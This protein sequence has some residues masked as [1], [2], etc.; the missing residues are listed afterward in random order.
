[1]A[2]ID[3]VAKLNHWRNKSQGAPQTIVYAEDFN[4]YEKLGADVSALLDDGRLSE[5]ALDGSYAPKAITEQFNNFAVDVYGSIDTLGSNAVFNVETFGAV[6][7]NST[8]CT[9]AIQAAI[10]AAAAAGGGVVRFPNRGI[11]RI[12]GPQRTGTGAQSYA[13]SGQL[14][15]PA[16]TMTADSR[17]VLTFE[18]PLMAPQVAWQVGSEPAHTSGAILLSN[19]TT[20]YVF[21]GIAGSAS[22]SP[23]TN[24]FGVFNNMT[25][26]TPANP[27]CGGLNALTLAGISMSGCSIDVNSPGNSIPVPTGTSYGL[28]LPANGNAAFVHATDCQIAGYPV[29]LSHAEHAQLHNVAVQMCA[30]GVRPQN[31]YTHGASY[32]RLLLQEC[33]IGIQ[34]RNVPGDGGTLRGFVDFEDHPGTVWQSTCFIDDPDNR[35]YGS[36]EIYSTTPLFKS[37]PVRGCHKLNLS[38]SL[39]GAVGW[40]QS[41]P[42]DTFKRTIDLPNML[43]LCDKSFHPWIPFTPWT[44]INTTADADGY[45]RMRSETDGGIGVAVVNWLS[46]ANQDS[47]TVLAVLRMRESG[48]E[49]GVIINR[50]STNGNFLFVTLHNDGYVKIGKRVNDND[51]QLAQSAAGLIVGGGTYKLA[52]SFFH[53]IGTLPVVKAYLDGVEVASYTLTQAETAVLTEQ[54]DTNIERGDGLRTWSDN[55]SY[56][57]LFKVIPSVT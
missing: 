27:Q 54:D 32:D 57:S 13:Y 23:I 5:E 3:F 40:M 49:I 52:A 44:T 9:A 38:D 11:Y 33:I 19:A 4:R 6:A 37:F 43:G 25:I 34:A 53:P 1:M 50:I 22:M 7:D 35:L 48:G 21:D 28:R 36:L 20:G 46:R 45:G 39:S 29:G 16:R 8:D 41:Y 18:G 42:L 15:F 24:V 47:R 56:C 14:L 51:T 31:Y 17:I 55:Q 30:V 12:N 26:R 10:D 2:R